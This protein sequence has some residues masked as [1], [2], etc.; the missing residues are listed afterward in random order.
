MRHVGDPDG[1]MGFLAGN[2]HRNEPAVAL[3]EGGAEIALR[4]LDRGLRDRMDA[5]A[6]GRRVDGEKG[7]AA[8]DFTFSP[9]GS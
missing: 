6:V 8:H 5:A 7:E 9:A 1:D 2:R 3:L 4:A